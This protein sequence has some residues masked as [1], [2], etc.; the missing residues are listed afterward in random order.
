MLMIKTLFILLTSL[1]VVSYMF[2]KQNIG[3]Q[4]EDKAN[5]ESESIF[6]IKGHVTAESNEDWLPHQLQLLL[7]FTWYLDKRPLFMVVDISRHLRPNIERLKDDCSSCQVVPSANLPNLRRQSH[8]SRASD[9]PSTTS[10]AARPSLSEICLARSVSPT[11]LS[12]WD[13]PGQASKSAKLS[14]RLTRLSTTSQLGWTPGP[15]LLGP[16]VGK[17]G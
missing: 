1:L 3:L 12:S 13:Q 15:A 4:F 10:E 16:K 8:Q 6:Y 11:K 9:W 17:L 14:P 5:M 7:F 2:I